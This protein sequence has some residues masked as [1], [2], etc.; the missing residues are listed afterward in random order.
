MAL[1]VTKPVTKYGRYYA[2]GTVIDEPTSV[3]ASMGRLLQWE[4]VV[5]PE[6]SLAAL[7]KPELVQIAQERGLDVSGLNKSELVALLEG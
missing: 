3:E 1:R 6:P 7:R 4:T 5:A 2:A